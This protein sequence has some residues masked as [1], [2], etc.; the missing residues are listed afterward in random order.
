M[1][2][3]LMLTEVREAPALAAAALREDAA[4][5]AALG[6]ALRARPPAFVATVARGSSD[7]AAS[8]GSYLFGMQT[9]RVAATLP[10]SLVTRYGATLALDNALVVGI[11]QSGA[12]PDLVRVL[13]AAGAAVRVAVVNAEGS[14]L[15]AEAD[16]VLPQK[17]GPERAVAATKSFVMTMVCL[18][19]LIAAWTED[20]G[21]T[22]ALERLPE[23]L[24]AALACDWSSGLEVFAAAERGAFVV[25]RGPVLAVAAE[26]AL[27]LKETSYMHAEAVSSAEI[28]HG[29]R[30]VADAGFPVLAFA[31]EDAGGADTRALAEA[32]SQAGVPVCLAAAGADLPL[33]APLHP[34]L[35]AIPAVL[36]FYGFAEAL[37]RLRGLDPDRPRGLR[38]ITETY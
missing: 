24:E 16:W 31:L 9:G 21:L 8:Y 32:F 6:R 18:A 22:A 37:A 29:P 36:A 10:P 14:P 34:L 35:D 26:A 15:A 27:K 7:H 11:S 2:T 13:A 1:M 17:A 4:L 38:K 5:Y 23:R 33:P 19:R 25:G 12:S 3:S 20:L 28:Q 30:A